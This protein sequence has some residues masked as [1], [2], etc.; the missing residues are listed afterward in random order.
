M[1]NW[2]AAPFSTELI[3]SLHDKYQ[4]DNFLD[5]MSNMIIGARKQKGGFRDPED[6][7]RLR[8]ILWTLLAR[9]HLSETDLQSLSRVSRETSEKRFEVDECSWPPTNRRSR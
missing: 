3:V 2:F 8:F 1:L 6:E 7:G 5:A 4:K 9:N